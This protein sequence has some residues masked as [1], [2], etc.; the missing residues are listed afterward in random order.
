MY[1]QNPVNGRF[2]P[3]LDFR[4]AGSRTARN[5]KLCTKH[6]WWSIRPHS[7][8][9]MKIIFLKVHDAKNTT[10]ANIAVGRE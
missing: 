10:L 7:K 9:Q 3:N 8:F 5:L 1:T 4:K 6:G 2:W